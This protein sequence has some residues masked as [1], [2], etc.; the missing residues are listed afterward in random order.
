MKA[1]LVP[2]ID[3]VTET[4]GKLFD[5]VALTYPEAD[6]EDFTNAYLHSNTR[7][8]IDQA[9]AYVCTL[10]YQDLFEFFKKVD[11]YELKSGKSIQ[12]FIPA[13]MGEFY[14]YYQFQSGL[15][16][17]EVIKQIPVKSLVKAYP[18]LHDLD[19]DLAVRKVLNALN[20]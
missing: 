6:T 10:D 8:Y 12:G 2:Y 3:E 11:H 7:K 16:S 13:W 14:S 20:T 1:K 9:S 19:L 4:Q 18:G 5:Y 17:T 15:S